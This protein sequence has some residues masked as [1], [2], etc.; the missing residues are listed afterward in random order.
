M[1]KAIPLKLQKKVRARANEKCEYCLLHQSF[2]FLTFHIEHIVSLKHGGGNEF[3][4]LALACPHCNSNKGTDLA[5]FLGSYQNIIPLFNPRLQNWKEH[6]QTENGEIIG[7]TPI[8]QATIK[9]LCVN[10]PDRLILRRILAEE[11]MYP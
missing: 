1:R 7:L 8:G 4:N 5:T 11:G 2:G 3:E 6:F 10:E 9:L